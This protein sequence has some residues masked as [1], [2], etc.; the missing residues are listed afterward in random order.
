MF[1]PGVEQS[2]LL[3][4]ERLD[5]LHL[6]REVELVLDGSH[7]VFQRR[8]TLPVPHADP[9]RLVHGIVHSLRC[10]VRILVQPSLVNET[11]GN[12]WFK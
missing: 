2:G 8:M 3:D 4:N 6:G 12:Y 7:E 9:P 5:R 10:G 1:G 11:T